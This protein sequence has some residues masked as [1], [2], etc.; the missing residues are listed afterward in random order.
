M[1]ARTTKAA[2]PAIAQATL[3][4]AAEQIRV[5]ALHQAEDWNNNSAGLRETTLLNEWRDNC[6]D[7]IFDELLGNYETSDRDT[8]L[9]AWSNAFDHATLKQ[10]LPANDFDPV[11]I[12]DIDNIVTVAHEQLMAMTAIFRCLGRLSGEREVKLL[13]EHGNLQAEDVANEIDQLRERAMQAGFLLG[14]AA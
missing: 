2:V 1:S 3:A 4:S 9:A 6:R 8:L 14:S 7:G 5:R 10:T 11:S 12:E 13:C